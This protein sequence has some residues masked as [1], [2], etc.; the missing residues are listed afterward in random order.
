M[1]IPSLFQQLD[2]SCPF[3]RGKVGIVEGLVYSYDLDTSG[4]P[5]TINHESYKVIGYCESCKKS[6]FVIPNANGTYTAY[7]DNTALPMILDYTNVENRV[8]EMEANILLESNNPF[9]SAEDSIPF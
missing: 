6:L 7:P 2:G 9:I 8:L 1:K 4:L 3:C 5:C